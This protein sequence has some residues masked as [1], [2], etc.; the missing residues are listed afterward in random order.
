MLTA[1]GF[2]F[3]LLVA[4]VL[5]LGA[6]D[7]RRVLLLLALTLL[8]WIAGEWLLFALRV[9]LAVPD[10]RV[11]RELRDER[12]PVDTLWVGRTFSVHVEVEAP[13]GLGLPYVQLGERL[14]TGI[15]T[16][17]GATEREASLLPGESAALDYRISCRAAGRIR[18]DGLRLQIADWQGFFNHVAFVPAVAEYRVLPPL[19]DVQG[20]RPTVKRLNLLPSPGVHRHLRPGTGSELLDLRD[21][22]PGDPPK[23][24]A[25]K[26][27]ARRDRLITK[28]FESEVPV[29]CTLFVDTSHAVRIGAPGQNALARLVDIAAAVA[30]ATTGV[31]DLTGLCL[32]DENGVTR[33]VRPARGPRHVVELLNLL[34]DAAGLSPATGEAPVETLLPLAYALARDVYPQLLRSELNRVPVLFPWFQPPPHEGRARDLLAERS[35]FAR[36]AG[37]KVLRW[38]FLVFALFPLVGVLA[39]FFLFREALTPILTVFLPVPEALL[40]ILGIAWLAGFVMLYSGVAEGFFRAIAAFFSPSRRRLTRWRKSLAALI[41]VREDLE[42]G[43][44]ATLLEDNRLLVLALQR[45]LAEHHVP[46]PLPLYDRRGRYL[47]ASPGKV[48]VLAN[49]L[50]RAVGRVRDNELFILLADLPEVV[51]RLDPLLRAVKVALARHH[52]VLVICPWPP[53]VPVPPTGIE[54]DGKP[55][56]P[57]TDLAV[58]LRKTTVRRLHEAHHRLRRAF[59]R[60]GVPVVCA[61]SGD[62]V[63]LVLERMNQLRGARIRR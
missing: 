24:I 63:G 40:P 44:L 43:G 10:L 41:A 62:P 23:T 9:R 42:P 8:L 2:Y 61:A 12:G 53:G 36:V 52:Q 11:R 28:E 6:F 58:V 4:A 25:W 20:N 32:F 7:E 33:Y 19:A 34:A 16:A 13:G 22:L 60:L 49:A 26:V 38:V 57:G 27:S 56:A 18:F 37:R 3:L 51:E 35:L 21:Y 47:F 59:A 17:G 14:P 50:L 31:R 54:P 45:F 30:Q 39:F 29:R 5:A 15:E 1:R 55:P 46:Y 48:E